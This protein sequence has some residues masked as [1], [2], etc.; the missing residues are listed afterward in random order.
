MVHVP[1]DEHGCRS[2]AS[3]WSVTH[4]WRSGHA[5]A[6]S[7]RPAVRCPGAASRPPRVAAR[8]A[9]GLRGRL[10][11]R[12][13]LRWTPARGAAPFDRHGRVFLPGHRP[14]NFFPAL[15]I[16]WL[17]VPGVAAGDLPPGAGAVRHRHRDHRAARVRRPHPRGTSS[18]TAGRMRAK[19]PRRGA[20]PC[21]TWSSASSVTAPR[22]RR[23]RRA[24]V[25]VPPARH[26]G[27]ATCRA[28]S[29]RAAS[30]ASACIRRRALMDA[31]TA[32][33]AVARLRGLRRARDLRRRGA[34]C[35]E[36]LACTV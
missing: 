2:S 13:P 30:A 10:R 26:A 36:A 21:S 3:T 27:A 15:R 34:A 20:P 31:T 5:V 32:R 1:V 14:S 9:P 4:A 24:A 11:R 16:G 35:G 6:P 33:G 8:D 17:V 7:S 12:V 19:F 29:A 18:A 23:E 25:A 28:G 22:S